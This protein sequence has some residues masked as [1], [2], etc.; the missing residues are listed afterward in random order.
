MPAPGPRPPGSAG[1]RSPTRPPANRVVHLTKL[2]EVHQPDLVGAAQHHTDVG[3]SLALPHSP[4]RQRP[5]QVHQATTGRGAPTCPSPHSRERRHGTRLPHGPVP[6]TPSP[7]I[8]RLA[9]HCPVEAGLAVPGCQTAAPLTNPRDPRSVAHPGAC[10]SLH[11]VSAPGGA[12]TCVWV[13]G[14]SAQLMFDLDGRPQIVVVKEGHP[15]STR[16][17]EPDVPSLAAP[18]GWS[19]TSTESGSSPM[20]LS[21]SAVPSDEPLSIT[22]HSTAVKLCARTERA[23]CITSSRRLYVGM[24]AVTA[25]ACSTAR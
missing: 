17:R 24:I 6:W 8:R 20:A 13:G 21:A 9:Q 11:R 10:S 18:R 7:T 23:D 19:R 25:T 16:G 14:Q 15:G 22:R 2:R 3:R 5:V 1:R 4:G 12:P